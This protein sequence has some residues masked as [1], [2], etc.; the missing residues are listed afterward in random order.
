M[1]CLSPENNPQQSDPIV[2]VIAIENITSFQSC[3]KC[4]SRIIKLEDE[5]DLGQCTKCQTL[6]FMSETKHFLSAKMTVKTTS[7]EKI[8]V[9]VFGSILLEITQTTEDLLTPLALIKAKPFTMRQK[10]GT[11]QSIERFTPTSLKF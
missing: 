8:D 1:E 10:D 11:I 4:K 5:D 9:R 2:N 6:Q 3:I 7:E